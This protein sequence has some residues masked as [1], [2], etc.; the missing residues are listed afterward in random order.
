MINKSSIRMI[1][2]NNNKKIENECWNEKAEN[3]KINK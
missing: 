3:Y 1:D 2:E